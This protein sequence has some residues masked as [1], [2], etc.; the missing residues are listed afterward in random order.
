MSYWGGVGNGNCI[1]EMDGNE[2]GEKER[3]DEVRCMVLGSDGRYETLEN[4][5][6]C[7]NRARI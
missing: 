4:A 5:K 2:R 3:E 6:E 1:D 7:E